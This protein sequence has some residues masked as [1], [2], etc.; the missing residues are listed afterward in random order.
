MMEHW[1]HQYFFLWIIWKKKLCASG[2]ERGNRLIHSFIFKHITYTFPDIHTV[3][4][5]QFWNNNQHDY[6]NDDSDDDA[7]DNESYAAQSYVAQ[8]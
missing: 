4:T 5:H 3:S 7:E 8:N 6:D 1:P 2:A